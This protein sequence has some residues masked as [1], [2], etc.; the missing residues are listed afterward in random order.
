MYVLVLW[1]AVFA[2]ML[3]LVAQHYMMRQQVYNNEEAL[4]IVVHDATQDARHAA[5]YKNDSLM[6]AMERISS[7]TGSLRALSK[8][9]GAENAS[10]MVNHDVTALLHQMEQQKEKILRHSRELMPSITPDARMIPE[11]PQSYDHAASRPVPP[12]PR[13]VLASIAEHT[14]PNKYNLDDDETAFSDDDD[15][16]RESD[17]EDEEDDAHSD[18]LYL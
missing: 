18:D 10:S 2:V 1:L 8:I 6:Y 9:F 14:D 16:G 13:S 11:L 12:P 15:E 17:T 3:F 7:G 5:A 4:A